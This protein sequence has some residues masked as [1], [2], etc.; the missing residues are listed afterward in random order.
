MA[1]WLTT[2][3]CVRSGSSILRASSGR[4]GAIPLASAIIACSLDTNT[5]GF[6]IKSRRIF[7]PSAGRPSAKYTWARE[8]RASEA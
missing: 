7:S 1:T 3:F 5:V 4:V 6:A 8:K 2:P